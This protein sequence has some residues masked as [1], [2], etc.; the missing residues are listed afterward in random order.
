[1]MGGGKDKNLEIWK[2]AKF[3]LILIWSTLFQQL[4]M[5]P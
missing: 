5:L 3:K 4:E 1:M 2:V